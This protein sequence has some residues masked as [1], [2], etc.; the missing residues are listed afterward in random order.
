MK[1]EVIKKV[2]KSNF[3]QLMLV[4][5]AFFLMVLISCLFAIR[6]VKKEISADSERAT[7][8]MV[9]EINSSLR[10]LEISTL[11]TSL[12]IKDYLDNHKTHEDIEKFMA[13]LNEGMVNPDDNILGFTFMGG[14]IEGNFEVGLDLTPPE[15]YEPQNRP[16]YTAAREANGRV[17]FSGV[18]VD[19]LTGRRVVTFSR[20]LI[21]SNGEDYGVVFMDMDINS[22]SRYITSRQ[23]MAGGYGMIVA[24]DGT[25]AM[26]PDENMLGKPMSALSEEHAKIAEQI[27][28]GTAVISS[29]TLVNSSGQRMVTFFQKAG[30]GWYVGMAVPYRNYYEDIYYMIM[31]LA[32]LGLLAT[33][34]LDSFLIRVG[35]EKMRSDEESVSKSSFLARMSHE[36]R[37]PLNTIIGMSELISRK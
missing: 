2:I 7:A 27:S 3:E 30:Y 34:F 13:N 15:G 1:I 29:T 22:L 6:I 12:S 23:F 10:E 9:A 18:Y 20:E 19:A 33:L 25:F 26:Y 32:S 24:A 21:G 37:T 16:W 4:F 5:F 11:I 35:A 31:I 8:I 14:V 36:M 17:A 28:S